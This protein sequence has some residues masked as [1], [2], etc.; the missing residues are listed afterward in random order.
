MYI[1]L[2]DGHPQGLLNVIVDRIGDTIRHGCDTRA[3]LNDDV[4]VDVN[5]LP[6]VTYRNPLD[7]RRGEWYLAN[8]ICAC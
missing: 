6:I 2:V 5:F 8:P 7:T 3:V 4:D 1:N